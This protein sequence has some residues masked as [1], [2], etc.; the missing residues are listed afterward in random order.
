MYG[1][2][3]AAI[4]CETVSI[5]AGFSYI[6]VLKRTHK[7]AKKR[8]FFCKQNLL[9]LAFSFSSQRA[10]KFCLCSQAQKLS[11]T[12]NSSSRS[13]C[14]T[15]CNAA[16]IRL[17][18]TVKHSCTVHATKLRTVCTLSFPPWSSFCFIFSFLRLFVCT[19]SVALA[20]HSHHYSSSLSIRTRLSPFRVNKIQ[21]SLIIRVH[22]S[23]S[24]LAVVSALILSLLLL[25]SASPLC[26]H[27]PLQFSS[28]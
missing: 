3:A 15:T 25:L 11:A 6:L 19:V 17:Q 26:N 28:L 22:G 8:L 13:R 7:R 14:S 16:P 18:C 2:L 20:L 23:S 24:P 10:A 12:S 27:R 9:H 1:P 4:S 21:V 5:F